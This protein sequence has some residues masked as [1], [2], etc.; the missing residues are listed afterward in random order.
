MKQQFWALIKKSTGEY[1]TEVI[2]NDSYNFVEML[3]V[4]KTREDARLMKTK[5]EKIVKVVI[6][7]E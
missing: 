1:L 3:H 4:Y 7:V 6:Y 2:E 5:R